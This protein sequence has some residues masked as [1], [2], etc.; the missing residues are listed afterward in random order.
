MVMGGMN[1][2]I[3]IIVVVK[4]FIYYNNFLKLIY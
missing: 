2:L 4:E 3:V 1:I